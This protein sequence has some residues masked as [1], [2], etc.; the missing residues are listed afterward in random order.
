MP[1][2]KGQYLRFTHEKNLIVVRAVTKK[3]R[4]RRAGTISR[5][6]KY[7]KCAAKHLV[8]INAHIASRNGAVKIEAAS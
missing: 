1:T 4:M 8:A 6:L 2:A 7:V 5:N 3:G